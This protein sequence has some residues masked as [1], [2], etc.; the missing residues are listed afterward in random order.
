M[1]TTVDDLVLNGEKIW[2]SNVPHATALVI[3][4]RFDDGLGS[5]VVDLDWDGASVEQH[6]T[7]MH[8]GTQSHLRFEDVEIPESNVLTRG[9]D[10]FLDQ[11]KALNW[12]RLGSA[13]LANALAGNALDKALSYARQREQF[14]QPIADFQGIEW[15]L[16]EMLKRL[17]AARTL[18]YRAALD[19]RAGVVFPTDCTPRWRSCTPPRAPNASSARRSRFTAPTAISRAT[20]WSTYTGW[21]GAGDS[22]LAPT[23]Y[24]R[25]RSRPN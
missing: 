17:E 15:K 18:T 14:G 4:V 19:P 7:N 1:R 16:A 2:V 22:R 25:T 8:G 5:V 10:G 6:Y 23:R 12:E 9:D 11:L 21:C 20:R 3:W 13:T 24:R